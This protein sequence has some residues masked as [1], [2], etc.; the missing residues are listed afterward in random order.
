MVAPPRSKEQEH[1]VL[2]EG[3]AVDVLDEGVP[4]LSSFESS[5]P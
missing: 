4:N 2:M 5:G 1:P 3:L